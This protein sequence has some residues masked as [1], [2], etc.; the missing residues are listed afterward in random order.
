MQPRTSISQYLLNRAEEADILEAAPPRIRL[1]NERST[2]RTRTLTPEEYGAIISQMRRKQQRYYTCLYEA[3]MRLREPCKL[4]WGKI[5]F[6]AGLIRL[7]AEDVKEKENRRTP[8]SWELRKILQELQREQTSVFGIPKKADLVFRHNTASQAH[9]D[10]N[11]MFDVREAWLRAVAAC[12]QDGILDD[13]DVRPHDLRRSAITRWTS[14]GIPR[15]IVMKCSGNKRGSVHDG[16]LNFSD[17]QLVTA[18]ESAGLTSAPKAKST[19]S[20]AV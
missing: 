13:D 11:P 8:I 3:A 1:K 16:Y 19:K 14:L 5:D 20:K 10:G 6:K 2:V 18:F 15:D 9:P 7:R 17:Q 12:V 4:T